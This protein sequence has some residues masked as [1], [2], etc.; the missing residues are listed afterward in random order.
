MES[1]PWVLKPSLHQLW[2]K[3]H[4][5]YFFHLCFN[6]YFKFTSAGYIKIYWLK[7]LE[8]GVVSILSQV[9]KYKFSEH[10]SVQLFEI[11]SRRYSLQGIFFKS[12]RLLTHPRRWHGQHNLTTNKTIWWYTKFIKLDLTW[13]QK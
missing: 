5:S 2:S 12:W 4:Y 13:S 11:F 9:G 10:V 1:V 6:S 7:K 3:T 8:L